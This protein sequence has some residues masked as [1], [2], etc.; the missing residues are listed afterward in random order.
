MLRPTAKPQLIDLLWSIPLGAC[1]IA[2]HV[3][4][5]GYRPYQI[6]VGVA[7]ML[8]IIVMSGAWAGGRVWAP[9]FRVP[10]GFALY[11]IIDIYFLNADPLWIWGSV[12][13]VCLV[14][15]RTAGALPAALG[16]FGI[17]FLGATVFGSHP[18]LF[19]RTSIANS[20]QQAAASEAPPTVIHVLL[21]EHIGSGGLPE[22]VFSASEIE[23]FNTFFSDRKFRIYANSH[24][25][26]A[27]TRDSVTQLMTLGGL[28]HAKNAKLS[29]NPYFFAML[30]R[31]Y[32]VSVI[33]SDVMGVC[34]EE[35][36]AAIDCATY[37]I[38]FPHPDVLATLKPE[39]R[40]RVL[41]QQLQNDYFGQTRVR[42][43]GLYRSLA[44]LTAAKER[45]HHF[46]M[47]HTLLSRPVFA[48]AR[49]R[50]RNAGRGEL[51]FI[52]LLEPHYPYVFRADCSTRPFS[53]WRATTAEIDGASTTTWAMRYRLYWEQM[54][55][56]WSQ[57][58]EL[59]AVVNANEQLN[60]AIIL[61][62]GDHGSRI[63]APKGEVI[64]DAQRDDDLHSTLFAVRGPGIV[65]GVDKRSVWLVEAF[66]EALK[67]PLA[68]KLQTC[69]VC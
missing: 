24:S 46:P 40:I 41:L 63:R 10:L 1:L 11:I 19:H 60:D 28:R 65:P 43:V 56:V 26:V 54:Q 48:E 25:E 9:L 21:D 29:L 49:T 45:L 47:M 18:V 34:S 17:A 22:E 36:R 7:A 30:E 16:T 59:L 53:E 35:M 20:A 32:R 67:L 3:I 8:G 6:E 52:H 31:G 13:A 37:S 42:H 58:D 4:G 69:L 55:C 15:G 68:A 5:L 44:L 64:S 27:D 50:L 61:L 23:Q 14:L 66:A 62:H 12:L 33:Q 2:P 39:E 38:S 57:V 51:Y